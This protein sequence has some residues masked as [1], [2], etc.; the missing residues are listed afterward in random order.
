MIAP[1]ISNPNHRGGIENFKSSFQN[2]LKDADYIIMPK[3]I[4]DYKYMNNIIA[5]QFYNQL[6][7]ILKNPTT[8][9]YKVIK[10]LNDVFD[11][12]LL[13]KAEAVTL[14]AIVLS[15]YFPLI[16]FIILKEPSFFSFEK[17]TPNL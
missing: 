17:A 1:Y 2:I 16:V 12:V 14:L 7:E 11:L 4:E 13:K 5:S 3:I 10:E 9:K 15:L 6:Y 8:P